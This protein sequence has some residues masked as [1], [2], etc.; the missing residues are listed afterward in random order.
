[1]NLGTQNVLFYP[2]RR[3]LR[4]CKNKI[5]PIAEFNKKVIDELIIKARHLKE[6]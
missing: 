4:D 2:S 1:M 6:N 3:T 5:R